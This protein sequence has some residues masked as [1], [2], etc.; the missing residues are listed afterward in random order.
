[1]IEKSAITELYQKSHDPWRYGQLETDMSFCFRL[2]EHGIFMHILTKSENHDAKIK[3]ALHYGRILV[4]NTVKLDAVHPDLWQMA[5][6]PKDFE[7]LYINPDLVKLIDEYNNGNGKQMELEHPCQDVAMFPFVTRTFGNHVIEMME[8]NNEW[9]GAKHEDKRIAGGYENVPTDDTH[10]HQVGWENEWKEM[11]RKYIRPIVYSDYNGYTTTCE[12]H[13]MFV[14]RYHLGGQKY[15]TPHND[16]STWTLTVALNERD[17][18]FVGG[19]TFF[20]RYQC[21]ASPSLVG[22]GFIFPGRLTHNHSGS[23]LKSGRRYIIV[24]FMDP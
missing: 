2:R 1:M 18:D 7:E 4:I 16:A 11:I 24:S 6:N 15:L 22:G 23:E 3:D 21:L 20:T 5:S 19:G 14:V 17:V 8:H 10:M 13:M 9:S 12:S